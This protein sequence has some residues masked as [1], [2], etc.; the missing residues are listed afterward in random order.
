MNILYYLPAIGNNNI[1]KKHEILLHNLNYIYNNIQKK[2]SISINFYTVSEEIKDSIKSLHFIENIYIYEKSG[3]LSELFLT[4]P[5][6]EYIHLYD[7]ILFVLDDV[8]IIN[9][10][11]QRMID[12]KN[13]YSIEIFSPKILNSTHSFM[14]S[15]NKLTINNFLEIYLLLLTPA[16]FI[17]YCSINTIENKWLWAVDFLFGYYNIKSCVIN[18]FVAQHMLPSNSNHSEAAHCGNE[19]LKKH[20]KY[21]NFNDIRRDY[22]PIKEIIYDY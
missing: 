20:T 12:I 21:N 11:I 13:K 18:D 5:H 17:K 14:N 10:D 7:Y 3:V 1:D 4:N 22:E 19:Y 8:K 6:N 9:M 15:N 2:F 16:D